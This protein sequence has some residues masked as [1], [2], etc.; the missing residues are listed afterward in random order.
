MA[1]NVV[2]FRGNLSIREFKA[3]LQALPITVAED[4]AKQ[5]AP[6]LTAFVQQ[7]F[8]SGVNVYGDAR[9]VGVDG[10]SLTLV[11]TGDTRR[12]LKFVRDGTLIRA[13]LG[14]R[15]ARYLIGKYR[16]LPMGDRTAMPVAWVRALDELVR[17]VQARPSRVAA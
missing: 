17:T 15:Y 5:A 6:L 16:I 12:A 2:K 14:P 3:H 1:G 8:D 4:I 7:A 13:H 9:P 11:H 10:Q